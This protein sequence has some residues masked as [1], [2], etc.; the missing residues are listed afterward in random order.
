MVIFVHVA[1]GVIALVAGAWNLMAQKGTRRHRRAGWIYTGAMAGLILTSFAIFQLT[2]A[3][4]PFH[5][6]AIVS[7]ATLTLAIYF[8]L[9]RE[10][11]DGWLEH[12]Y[13]WITF[14]YVGLV[15]ATGSHFAQYGPAGWSMWE[16]GALWWGV[17]MVIGFALIFWKKEKVLNRL[18]ARASLAE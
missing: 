7:G 15:M 5:V 2:G 1:L 9:R 3:F 13:F 18:R 4:G 6:M 10:Y 16:R 12:H 11:H 17:P 14:S 8:P